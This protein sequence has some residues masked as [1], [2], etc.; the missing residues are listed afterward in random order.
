MT[1]TRPQT[2]PRTWDFLLTGFIVFIELLLVVIFFLAAL[3]F[4]TLNSG[5]DVYSATR[6]Q[7]GQQVCT[8]APPL[9]AIISIPWAI[10]RVA[11]RKIG[12]TIALIG[13]VL[14]ALSF[15]AGST[16]MQ[17]GLPA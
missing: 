12:F 11:R 9:F 1:T 16:L 17:S 2:P 6:V 8:F 7:I 10:F 15:F 3:T 14:M 4:G 13:L 5:A